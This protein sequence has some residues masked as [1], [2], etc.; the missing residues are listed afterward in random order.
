MFRP[1]ASNVMVVSSPTKIADIQK[2]F[3]DYGFAM[4]AITLN[5]LSLDELVIRN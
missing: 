1:E 2:G 5:D 3:E 4:K